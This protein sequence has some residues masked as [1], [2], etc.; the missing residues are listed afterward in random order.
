MSSFTLESSDLKI[1][2]NS[3]TL[4]D[5]AD[6]IRQHL[7]NKLRTFLGEWFLDVDVGVPY[8]QEILKKRPSFQAVSQALKAAIIETPGVIELTFFQF[9]YLATRELQLEFSADTIDGPI[10]FTQVIE[11]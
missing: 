3:L 11:V 2:N 9:D 1:T 4:T 5:G 10:D 8:F 7:E 6:A